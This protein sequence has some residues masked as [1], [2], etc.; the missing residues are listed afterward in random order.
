M[1]KTR[2]FAMLAEFEK[3]AHVMSAAAKVRDAGYS[4]WD[5]HTPYPVHGMDT[6]MGIGSP[7]WAASPDTPPACS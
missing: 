2:P 5:V 3:P 1:P 6:A 4:K 7:S